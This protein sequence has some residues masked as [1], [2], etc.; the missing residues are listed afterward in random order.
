[1]M[2]VAAA[3][4]YDEE[5]DKILMCQRAA[6]KSHAGQW[7]FPGGKVEEGE[8]P[9]IALAR[10]LQEEMGIVIDPGQAIPAGFASYAYPDKHVVLML[11]LVKNWEG[12][13]RLVEHQA[14]QWVKLSELPD[15]AV[16]PADIP[17]IDHLLC[18]L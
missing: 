13:P 15:F 12:T 5:R 11:F 2:L 3:A 14:M 16:L 8:S 4:L 17:L 18:Y 7:E 6:H 1:M 9:E 10:E